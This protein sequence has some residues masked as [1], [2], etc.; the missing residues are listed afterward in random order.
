MAAT[1]LNI[2]GSVDLNS[3][4]RFTLPFPLS[5]TEFGVY[6]GPFE[7]SERDAH[8]TVFAEPSS[9]A[10]FSVCPP[11][12]SSPRQT[13]NL[14]TAIISSICER[15]SPSECVQP[16]DSHMCFQNSQELRASLKITVPLLWRMCVILQVLQRTA[17]RRGCLLSYSQAEPGRKLT[18]PSP[19]LI[20]EPFI[21][22]G[23]P[24]P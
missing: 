10:P 22:S 17:K 19:C 15:S 24:I 23:D 2:D 21:G 14:W 3:E 11:L 9:F 1:Q 18:Q 8:F 7:V 20:A 4:G 12:V 16:L 6:F 5:L 13:L